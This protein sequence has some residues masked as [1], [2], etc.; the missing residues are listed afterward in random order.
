MN[1]D[2]QTML[3]MTWILMAAS[4][5]F[6]YKSYLAVT[7]WFE[8]RRRRKEYASL[9]QATEENMCKGPHTWDTI[10]L[11]LAGL[12]VDRYMVCKECGFVSTEGSVKLNGPALEIYK[13][14]LRIRQERLDRYNAVTQKKNDEVQKLMNVMVR[15]CIES[16]DG[17]LHKNAEALQQFYRKTVMELDSLYSKLNKELDEEERRG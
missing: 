14:E 16:F 9:E 6:A 12:P 13:N 11:A 5:V 15:R 10:K 1:N 17:D 4:G 7:A 8:V 2:L 3:F